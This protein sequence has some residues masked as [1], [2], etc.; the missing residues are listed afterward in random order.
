[1]EKDIRT[2]LQLRAQGF[3]LYESEEALLRR[4][5]LRTKGQAVCRR[6]Q[7]VIERRTGTCVRATSVAQA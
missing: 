4:H 5:D 1:M 3:A 2:L 6:L 7:A